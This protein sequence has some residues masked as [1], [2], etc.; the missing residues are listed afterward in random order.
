MGFPPA[1]N[2][3]IT[4]RWPNFLSFVEVFNFNFLLRFSKSTKWINQ[5]FHSDWGLVWVSSFLEFRSVALNSNSVTIHN[6]LPEGSGVN[7]ILFKFSKENLLRNEAWRCVKH[8]NFR[9]L[10]TNLKKIFQVSI[11][12]EAERISSDFVSSTTRGA[13][14]KFP[15]QSQSGRQNHEQN[16]GP[17]TPP[18]CAPREG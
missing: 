12:V 5:F 7:S 13:C 8:R 18:T 15:K 10:P 6:V 2:F 1:N 4:L 14:W 16:A 11:L 9:L 3:Y 17:R